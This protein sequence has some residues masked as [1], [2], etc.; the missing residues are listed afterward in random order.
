VGLALALFFGAAGLRGSGTASADGG[1]GY[2]PNVTTMTCASGSVTV[3]INWNT[4]GSGSQFVDYSYGAGFSPGNYTGMGPLVATQTRITIT[5]LA[6]GST[7]QVRIN[8]NSPN[9]WT[10]TT[11]VTVTL[12]SC[13]VPPPPPP[14]IIVRPAPPFFPPIRPVPPIYPPIQPVPPFP[15]IWTGPPWPPFGPPNYPIMPFYP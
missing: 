7:V 8:T 6:P 2:F 3:I 9:G 14:I 13:P 4:M 1:W 10:T 5:G 15:P 11:T 12:P